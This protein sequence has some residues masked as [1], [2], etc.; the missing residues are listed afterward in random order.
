MQP[1]IEDA[2]LVPRTA[3]DLEEKVDTYCVY[4]V[5][6]TL[7]G[8][9]ALEVFPDRQGEICAVVVDDTYASMGIGRKMIEYL[10]D[11]ASGLRLKAV[12]V[13]TTRTSDWFQQLGFVPATV[14]DLPPQR[15]RSYDRKRQSRIYRK[16]LSRRRSKIL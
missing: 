12:F 9:A 14:E 8:C 6:G 10:M 7:H 11:R 4:E 13:L 1:A 3:A 16:T 15:R 2:V 5:D